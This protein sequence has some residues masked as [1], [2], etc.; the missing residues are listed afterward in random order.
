MLNYSRGMEIEK[1]FCVDLMWNIIHTWTLRNKPMSKHLAE[2]TLSYEKC[3]K[4]DVK[5]R[6]V[7]LRLS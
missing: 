4:K 1:V 7:A 6:R 2:P 3:V 5:Y